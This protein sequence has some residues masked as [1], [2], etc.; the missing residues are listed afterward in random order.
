M[1]IDALLGDNQPVSDRLR[2]DSEAK[3]QPGG[4]YLGQ[5][6]DVDHMIRRQALYGWQRI[7]SETQCAVWVVLDEQRTVF[8]ND[9]GNA[10]PPLEGEGP[11]GRVLERWNQV[12]QLDIVLAEHVFERLWDHTIVVSRDLD[13]GRLIRAE[14]L[15]GT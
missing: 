10:M 3:P 14:R 6:A 12:D 2:C 7:T 13:I 15:D 9:L 1:Q 8:G 5:G 11:T 4:E